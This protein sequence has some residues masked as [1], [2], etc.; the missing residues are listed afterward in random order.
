MIISSV[1]EVEEEE[2]IVSS[3]LS[4]VDLHD[5]IHA[6]STVKIILTLILKKP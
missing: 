6:I 3:Q 2:G 4:F 1:V 5:Y